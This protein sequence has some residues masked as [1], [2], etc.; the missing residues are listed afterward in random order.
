MTRA[1]VAGPPDERFDQLL[2]LTAEV[3][4]TRSRTT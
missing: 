1:D 3:S 2:A 4:A